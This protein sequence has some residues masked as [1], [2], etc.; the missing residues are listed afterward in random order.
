M[1]HRLHPEPGH[2]RDA[3][4]RQLAGALD[5]AQRPVRRR[6]LHRPRRSARPRPDRSGATPCRRSRASCPTSTSP[7]P[8]PTRSRARSSRSPRSAACPPP[9]APAA[10]RRPGFVPIIGSLR[11]LRLHR[12]H[13]RL[14][15]PGAAARRRTGSTVTIYV[16]DGPARRPTRSPPVAAA[17]AVATAAAAAAGTVAAAAAATAGATAG[18]DGR[19]QRPRRRRRP[20][21]MT[22]GGP[23]AQAELAAYLRG[24]GTAVGAAPH[25][26]LHHA[27]HLAHRPHPLAGRPGLLDR[28]GDQLARS[29]RLV[30]LRGQVARDHLGLGALLR[31][32]LGAAGVRER[33][34]GLT[35][36]LGL[37][38]S[39]P[40][41]SSSVSSR[42]SLPATSAL[43]IAVS[44]IRSVEERDLVAG[45]DGGGEVGAQ[46]VLEVAHGPIVAPRQ[47]FARRRGRVGPCDSLTP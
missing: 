14:H 27:H 13:G 4:R 47:R 23:L 24:D 10:A 32:A 22:S 19:R 1:V 35:P 28:P 21:R 18:A 31:G 39:T 37:A 41:T 43:V 29:R 45:L 38:L 2:R 40:T 34:R 30:E 9:T 20:V 5:H 6:R 26:R 11:R 33:L 36:L 8:T 25:L 7:P 17:V 12:G 3:R 15:Q 16:S 44:T 42:A 46:P